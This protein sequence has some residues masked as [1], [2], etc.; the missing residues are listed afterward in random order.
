LFEFRA[1]AAICQRNLLIARKAD[2]VQQYRW[3]YLN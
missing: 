1:P 3:D 2:H